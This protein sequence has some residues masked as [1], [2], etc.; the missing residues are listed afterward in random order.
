LLHKNTLNIEQS[1]SIFKEFKCTTF[2][3]L[4][5]TWF[6]LISLHWIR[7]NHGL[8]ILKTNATLLLITLKLNFKGA[9]M[10][11][12]KKIL[13]AAIA[14]AAKK[15]DGQFDI[16][17]EPYILHPLTVMNLLNTDDDEL[18]IIAVLHD[19]IEDTDV[20]FDHLIEMGMTER[21]IKGIRA[22][23][24]I[25]GQSTEEYLAGIKANIDAIRVKLCDLR[26]NMDITRLK[27]LTE[28][29]IARLEKYHAM[30]IELK[31]I[32]K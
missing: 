21:I 8:N 3:I 2:T 15:H 17:G 22:L 14:L 19:I 4:K 5:Q 20:T 27:K 25:P 11:Q 12:M 32:S 6:W 29:S 18:K 13:S 28:K 7:L 31:S 26:H 9:K 23:T 30:Y 1:R 16:G 10:K 24:K